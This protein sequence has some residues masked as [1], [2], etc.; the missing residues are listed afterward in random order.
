MLD[1]HFA[2]FSFE[3]KPFQLQTITFERDTILNCDCTTTWLKEHWKTRRLDASNVIAKWF[4]IDSQNDNHLHRHQPEKESTASKLNKNQLDE[5]FMQ[6]NAN[7]TYEQLIDSNLNRQQ[8]LEA[9]LDQVKCATPEN[10]P[11]NDLFLVKKFDEKFDHHHFGNGRFS[12]IYLTKIRQM[13]NDRKS[14]ILDAFQHQ[15]RSCVRTATNST[16]LNEIN[17]LLLMVLAFLVL[18]FGIHTHTN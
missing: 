7:L 5:L 18:K 10:E 2:L 14:S 1:N 4:S 12:L 13:K 11:D 6:Q 9:N 3:Q 15:M 17:Y 16:K 8:N